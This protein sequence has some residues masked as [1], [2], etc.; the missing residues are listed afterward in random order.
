[1][2][3]HIVSKGL[4]LT[5]RSGAATKFDPYKAHDIANHYRAAYPDYEVTLHGDMYLKHIELSPNNGGDV[6]YVQEVD[7][8]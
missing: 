1:M 4:D 3:A 5:F 6:W 8:D 2:R 7:R